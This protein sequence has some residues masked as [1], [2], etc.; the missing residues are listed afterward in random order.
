[1]ANE[2]KA[3]GLKPVGKIGGGTW[4]QGMN[5]YRI[6][7][8][9]GTSI[10]T[11]DLVKQV[12]GGGI[13]RAAAGEDPVLGVFNGVS[14]VDSD[15]K[16]QY[17]AYWPASTA[18][19]NI[20]AKVFDDP[21]IIYEIQADAAFPIADLFGNFDTVDTAAGN[22]VSGV[23]GVELGV[24]T[25]NTTDIT[26]KALDISEDPRN[27]DVSSANTNV[28]VVIHSHS[29]GGMRGAGLA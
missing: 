6:A 9:Y 11:G 24:S 5:R 16:Q 29:I 27:S 13:E 14:Y 8:T 1:M 3:F 4:S 21:D 19:T 23:S 17:K 2:D 10:F 7:T 26:L 22:T 15:G 28:R 20:F 18:G 12:T 25:G